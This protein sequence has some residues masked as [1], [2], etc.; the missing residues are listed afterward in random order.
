MKRK[1]IQIADST[2][3]VSLP[4]KW[5]L[6]HGIK[7]GQEL[8]VIEDGKKLTVM[9]PGNQ[10][11][12]KK[13]ELNVG[14]LK[15]LM[16]RAMGVLYKSGYDEIVVRYPKP[17]L[18]QTIQQCL[19]DEL[20]GYEIIEQYPTHCVI[21]AVATGSDTEFDVVL[22][23]T[24]LLLKSML[25]G[26][27]GVMDSGDKKALPGLRFLEKSNN[28]Y[29]GY[30]RRII[31]KFGLPNVGLPAIYYCLVE[32]IEKIADE[33]K[34]LCDYLQKVN[35]KLNPAVTSI[36]KDVLKLYNQTY[37]LHYSF[38]L[39]KLESLF[40]AKTALVLN[41]RKIQAEAKIKHSESMHFVIN[42]TQLFSNLWSFEF[43]LNL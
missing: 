32:E 9:P 15:E 3:L 28:K 8:E 35:G 39:N 27:V 29:T 20:I 31:N 12:V 42:L 40:A 43:A 37:D 14:E 22:R 25:E 34:Y 10:N 36:F 2:Q 23:R 33:A 7:K 17:E 30:C 38:D 5:A 11:P 13:T 18:V 6:K 19:Q 26:V 16:R 24:Y 41:A 1:V 4:R 21:K